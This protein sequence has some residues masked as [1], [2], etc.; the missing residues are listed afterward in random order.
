ML[1]KRS[2]PSLVTNTAVFDT[3]TDFTR[4]ID[5]WFNREA[6]AFFDDHVVSFHDRWEF[7]DIHTDTVTETVVEVLTVT[8]FFDDLTGGAVHFM[9]S[10]TWLDKSRAA[11]WAQG[12]VVNI[13][14][15]LVWFA[16]SDRT[17]H[18]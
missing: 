7:M 13:F 9:G 3:D 17:S 12:S 1:V 10:H 16:D 18:I 2:K 14:F 8:S 15:E 5:T 11:C 6:H 4:D